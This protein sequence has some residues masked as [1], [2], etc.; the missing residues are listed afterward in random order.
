[1][2]RQ[3]EEA[4]ICDFAE[5]YHIFDY[6]KLPLSTVASLAAGLR[7]DS[8]IKMQ[9]S[10][11]KASPEMLMLAGIVDRLSLLVWAQT[12]DATQGRN[13]PKLLAQSLMPQAQ[14]QQG[15]SFVSGKDFEEARAE[16]LK[17][18]EEGGR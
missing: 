12:K 9:L 10:G 1:M 8:R 4:L 11:I 16:M 13:R 5:T 2:L 17:R 7:D 14:K 15:Q 6:K 18:I 3:D